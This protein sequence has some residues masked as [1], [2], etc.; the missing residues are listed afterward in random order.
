MSTPLVRGGHVYALDRHRGLMCLEMRTGKV[1][2]QDQHVTPRGS[3]PQATLVWA[4][5]RAVILNER[6]ELLLAELKPEGYS[7]VGKVPL[8]GPTW[9]HPAY[10]DGCV[11]ARNDEEIVCVSLG[12]EPPAGR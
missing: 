11:F 8:L 3:N 2:W 12:G 10:A 7:T 5:E 9:A 1:L 4:G 6:G